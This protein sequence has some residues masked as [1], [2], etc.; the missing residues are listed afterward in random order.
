MDRGDSEI[1]VNSNDDN[2]EDDV[3]VENVCISLNT[4]KRKKSVDKGQGEVKPERLCRV[5]LI[6]KRRLS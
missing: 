1:M 2:M 6:R 5:S 4:S 3:S